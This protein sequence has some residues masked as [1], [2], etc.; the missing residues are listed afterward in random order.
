MSL[1]VNNAV[2]IDD[3]RSIDTNV[4]IKDS[5]YSDYHGEVSAVSAS[6][7]SIS[8]AFGV[9]TL[10]MSSSSS[11]SISARVSGRSTMLLLDRNTTG[12]RTPTFNGVAWANNETP[13][14]NNYR[15]WIVTFT[16]WFSND[17]VGAAVG[18]DT[19]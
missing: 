3:S 1:R 9:N 15:Y 6:N 18:Y 11:H 16:C 8:M 5:L 13:Q 4:N 14:W 7:G 2:V 12:S 10:N 17:V 19:I